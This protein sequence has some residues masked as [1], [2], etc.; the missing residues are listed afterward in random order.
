MKNL[1]RK[2]SYL[3]FLGLQNRWQSASAGNV[4]LYVVVL[5]LIFGVLGV[6]M[7]SLFASSTASTVTRNDTRRSIYMAESGMR[8]AFSELR[9]A[10]F[11]IDFMI[12]TL[13]TTTYTVTDA[14]SFTINVFSPWFVRPPP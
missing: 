8:Y 14:G 2:P 3:S 11:D 5:M 7:V 4:L 10:D 9:K 6:V 1:P 12:D 13:N